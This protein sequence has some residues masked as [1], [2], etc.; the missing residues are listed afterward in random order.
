[1][2]IAVDARPLRHPRTGIGK[3]TLNLLRHLSHLDVEFLL[4]GG[5]QAPMEIRSHVARARRTSTMR[6]LAGAQSL[7][8]IGRW[9]VQDGAELFWSPRHHLPLGIRGMPSVLTVHDLVWRRAPGT[10]PAANRIAERLLFPA[11]VRAASLILVPSDRSRTD[12]VHY[13]PEV[14]NRVR[15][16]PLGGDAWH[17][18]AAQDHSEIDPSSDP[19][20]LF[21]GGDQPR[22]NLRTLLAAV[23][24]LK[25]RGVPCLRLVVVGEVSRRELTQLV[26][27]DSTAPGARV[28]FRGALSDSD[29]QSAYRNCRFVVAPYLYEGFGLPIAEAAQFGKPAIVT[30]NSALSDLAGPACLQVDPMSPDEIAAAIE[31][32]QASP[33]LYRELSGRALA[34]GVSL[35]WQETARLT[36]RAFQE[37]AG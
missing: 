35:T 6:W 2:L 14:A 27:A 22:K 20:M 25:T 11:S 12:L 29:L 5:D 34:L 24:L 33:A 26:A 15:V 9:A 1:M 18:S 28:E 8:L 3:Y 30:R 19:Y 32:M 37:V 21:I 31:R 7:V 16:I 23:K 10:M 13:Y 36:H 4:Y 17:E